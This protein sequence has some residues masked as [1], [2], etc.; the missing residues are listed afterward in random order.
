MRI[1]AKARPNQTYENIMSISD[2]VLEARL[3]NNKITYWETHSSKPDWVVRLKESTVHAL[4]PV[5]KIRRER[6]F[7]VKENRDFYAVLN[8]HKVLYHER[9]I[10][11]KNP[12]LR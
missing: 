3:M 12:K 10:K 5:D 6:P 7:L 2:L 8:R 11:I 4:F 1:L 9:F